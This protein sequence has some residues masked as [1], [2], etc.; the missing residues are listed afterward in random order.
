M[1]Y[2]VV[3]FEAAL[4]IVRELSD[5]EKRRVATS[6]ASELT[7]VVGGP[8]SLIQLG[9]SAYLGS[10]GDVV[11]YAMALTAGYV[12]IY[13][14]LTDLECSKQEEVRGRRFR[15]QL[16]YGVFDLIAATSRPT[17]VS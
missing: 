15:S 2:E 11:R 1:E 4:Q 16:V 14:P 10:L 8:V 6:L 7:S 13:R 12:A 9:S 17:I 5:D 3:L